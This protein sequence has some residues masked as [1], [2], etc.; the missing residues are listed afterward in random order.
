MAH[1][2]PRSLNDN[3][4]LARLTVPQWIAVIV[5]GVSLWGCAL[6]A[7]GIHNPNMHILAVA[8]PT[9][10]LVAPILALGR[11]GI[12]KYPAQALG[13]AW[14]RTL[15]YGVRVARATRAHALKGGIYATIT[16]RQARRRQL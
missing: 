15:R 7:R 2:T 9:V 11:G 4:R 5:G 14:R 1:R 13:F 3:L 16:Y 10:L 6:L 12:E 8:L